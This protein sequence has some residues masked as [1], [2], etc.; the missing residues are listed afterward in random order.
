[1]YFFIADLHLGHENVIR[2]D[3][4]P[5]KNMAEMNRVI[6][7][8]WNSRVTKDDT[9]Y[10]LGDFV[11]AKEPDWLSYVTAFHGNKVL[12]RGNHDPKEFSPAL[13]KEFVDVRDYMEITDNGRRVIMSHYPMPF[14]RAA[15]GENCWML[16]GHVH[17]TREYVL[18]QKL[19]LEIKASCKV[20]GYARG[21][22]VNVGCMLP[23]MD[24]TPR[25]FMEIVDGYEKYRQGIEADLRKKQEDQKII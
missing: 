18:L 11:W 16:Y 1:M 23:Y 6:L 2:F 19:R 21:N 8:N 20:K 4:R 17:M 14:H 7:D 24:Y 25:T 22:F 5:F 10:I 15:Y 12:I 9:V 3:N 13:R